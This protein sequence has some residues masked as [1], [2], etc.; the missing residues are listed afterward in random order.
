[1]IAISIIKN[2]RKTTQKK[3][4]NERWLPNATDEYFIKI[5]EENNWASLPQF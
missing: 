5:L 1:M 2:K 3:R 4:T